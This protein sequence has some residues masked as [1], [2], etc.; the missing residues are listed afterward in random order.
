MHKGIFISFDGMEGTGKTTSISYIK[1]SIEK[2]ICE[3][4]IVTKEPGTPLDDV[5]QK[6]RHLVLSP[7]NIV[8]N[9]A[10]KYLFMADR[11]QHVHKIIKPNLENGKIVITDRYIDSTYAY[12]GYG[13]GMGT[14]EELEYANYLNKKTTNGLLPD[15]TILLTVDPVKGF[16]R[17]SNRKKEFATL[18]RIE[19]E[20]VDFH[21]R[22]KTAFE[23]IYEKR[24]TRNIVLIDTTNLNVD[25]QNEKIE[26]IV[27]DFI[28]GEV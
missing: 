9:E 1:K 3:T 28:Q 23:E 6:I 11:C 21:I 19:K 22:L 18:D 7:E 10:E 24:G 12:Q 4:P 17:I 27:I 26:K 8:D 13:R 16:E 2:N 25:Q 14:K 5:C 15:L 20:K